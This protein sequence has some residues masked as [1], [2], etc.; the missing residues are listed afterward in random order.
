MTI[1]LILVFSIYGQTDT[2][3]DATLVATFPTGNGA[4]ELGYNK[5]F[6]PVVQGPTSVCFDK[7]GFLYISDDTNT[8]LSIFNKNFQYQSS[9]NVSP[10]EGGR[11]EIDKNGDVLY[12]YDQ[13][14]AEKI[15]RNGN[16]IFRISL[17]DTKYADLIRSDSHLL[18]CD[19]L[20]FAQLEDGGIICIQNPSTDW[21][22]N[23]SKILSNDETLLLV[24]EN[25]NDQL[26]N[27]NTNSIASG[28]NLRIERC[29]LRL[30]VKG[31][32]FS[33]TSFYGYMLYNGENILT[34]DFKTYFFAAF[35]KQKLARAME[36]ENEYPIMNFIDYLQPPTTNHYIGKDSEGNVYWRS[37]YL[38]TFKGGS[39][40]ELYIVFADSGALIDLFK[41]NTDEIKTEKNRFV[42]FKAVSPEGDL[43]AISYD[44]KANYLYKVKRAW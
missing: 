7:N 42:S 19:N 11:F 27:K 5:H 1:F 26:R 16:R 24:N 2:F 17:R 6:S 38:S 22:M 33:E 34:Y 8:R 44:G 13:Y 23:N 9:I 21:K 4:G 3:Y 43:Y 20:A 18:I 31:K 35:Q 36:K 28:N 30:E 12:F 40:Y 32:T 37:G 41:I 14:S 29:A 25:Q 10:H 39:K 15:N